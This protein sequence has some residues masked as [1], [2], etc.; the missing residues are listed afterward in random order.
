MIPLAD[1]PEAVA[2][3]APAPANNGPLIDPR[4]G[5]GEDPRDSTRRDVREL[6]WK[7]GEW[8]ADDLAA[9]LRLAP[10]R[11]AGSN[12]WALA[13]GRTAG[14]RPVVAN[15]PHVGPN[16]PPPWYLA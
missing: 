3:L 12:S 10:A 16:L 4:P 14:G 13:E 2:A 5:P 15:D 6:V 11:V 8:L 1:G 9:F 7:A